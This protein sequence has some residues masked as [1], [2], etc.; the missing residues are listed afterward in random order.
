MRFRQYRMAPDHHAALD[1]ALP[2]AAAGWEWVERRNKA[3]A[4]PTDFGLVRLAAGV[5]GAL[6]VGAH[7]EATS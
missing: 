1:A 7:T 6:K 4:H 2:G 3:A 5:E